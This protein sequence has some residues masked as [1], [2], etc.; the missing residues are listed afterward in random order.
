MG[1]R[2]SRKIFIQVLHGD[3][4]TSPGMLEAAKKHYLNAKTLTWTGIQEG[5]GAVFGPLGFGVS[6]VRELMKDK[7]APARAL[8]AEKL[9]LDHSRQALRALQEAADDNNWA[10]RAA[11]AEALGNTG[12]R[13]ALPALRW[14]LDDEKDAVRC[15]A[16]A[17]IIRLKTHQPS[18]VNV[19][20]LP[21]QQR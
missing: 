15:M 20:T 6:A 17:S 19:A 9:S 18:R 21:F 12:S 13:A 8:S 7:G 14:L 5:A 11:V 2:S 10:V 3:R 1:D 16:A 4:N